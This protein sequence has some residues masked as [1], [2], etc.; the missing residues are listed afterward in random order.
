MGR[1]T[2]L[3]DHPNFKPPQTPQELDVTSVVEYTLNY[4]SSLISPDKVIGESTSTEC[5][6]VALEL[7]EYRDF[8]V[9]LLAGRMVMSSNDDS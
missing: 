9:G 4:C 5:I 2:R 7:P 3:S 8:I 6:D 1:S